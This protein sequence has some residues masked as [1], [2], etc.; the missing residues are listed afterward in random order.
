M[1][2]NIYF[3]L[4]LFNSLHRDVARLFKSIGDFQGVDALVEQ[5]LRLLKQSASEHH[6]ACGA[7]ADLV[8]LGFRQFDQ[9]LRHFVLHLY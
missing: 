7:V 6:H 1:L 5:L 4:N 8:I 9:E 2:L 3:F